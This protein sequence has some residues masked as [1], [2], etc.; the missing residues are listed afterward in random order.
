MWASQKIA[1][2][3]LWSVSRRSFAS[4]LL[5]HCEK[6]KRVPQPQYRYD[7]RH[8]TVQSWIPN[9]SQA[10]CVRWAR[11]GWIGWQVSLC[12]PLR[13]V[14]KIFLLLP[15]FVGSLCRPSTRR[16]AGRPS[17]IGIPSIAICRSGGGSQAGMTDENENAIHGALLNRD[18]FISNHKLPSLPGLDPAIHPTSKDF[19]RSRWMRGSS[20][21]MT[22]RGSDST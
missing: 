14:P 18:A 11:A 16:N 1:F 4:K 17:G 13:R 7:G 6:G 2:E 5:I 20:P 15:F 8:G 9:K 3:I 19:L 22:R 12:E 21:R 10:C